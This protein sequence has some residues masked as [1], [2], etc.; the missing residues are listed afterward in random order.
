MCTKSFSGIDTPSSREQTSPCQLNRETEMPSFTLASSQLTF[1][2]AHSTIDLLG[3]GTYKLTDPDQVYQTVT[4]ALQIGYRL[5]DT[6][7]F[8]RNEAVIGRALSESSIARSDVFLTTKI[9]NDDQRSSQQRASIEGSLQDLQTDYLD[10][11]LIHWPVTDKIEETWDVLVQ[12]QQEGLVH[13]IGVS[14]F[15]VHH[16]K[17]I[18]EHSTCMPSLNQM[19]HH[20]SMRD[21]QTREFCREHNVV[22]QAW[23][24]FG[25]GRE[26]TDPVITEIASVHECTPAQVILAYLMRD[27]VGVI[28]KATNKKRLEENFQA[29]N[30]HL[31]EAECLRIDELNTHTRVNPLSDPDNFAF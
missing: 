2:P 30:V 26:L 16:L 5:I 24:P 4:D 29:L 31:S 22:Y 18:S 25:R 14:N 20:P 11:V 3:L 6:A 7:R 12:A 17:R 13:H 8:Y 10:M 19:E 15:R 1:T 23:S 21:E 28:P 27:T 9:W